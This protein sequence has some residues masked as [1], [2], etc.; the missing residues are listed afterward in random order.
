[1]GQMF[2]GVNNQ[3]LHTSDWDLGKNITIP[4]IQG[5]TITDNDK[6]AI[7]ANTQA[8]IAAQGNAK[9]AAT[10]AQNAGVNK[11][12]AAMTGSQTGGATTTDKR[13]IARKSN[14]GF[15][16]CFA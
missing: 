10:A 3:F 8:E 12:A 13:A 15:K 5:K 9:N 14:N 16:L 1:M 2:T 6:A 11:S 7:E 4:T